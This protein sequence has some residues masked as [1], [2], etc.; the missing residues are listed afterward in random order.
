MAFSPW[1]GVA[2]HRPLGSIMRVRKVV[3]EGSAKFRSERNGCPIHEPR[4]MQGFPQA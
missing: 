3:Y 2:A 1:H 4:D